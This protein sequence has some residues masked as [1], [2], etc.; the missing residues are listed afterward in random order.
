MGAY[1]WLFACTQNPPEA[2]WNSSVAVA[3]V[4]DGFIKMTFGHATSAS[5]E[6]PVPKEEDR[7]ED[8][9]GQL[10]SVA[11]YLARLELERPLTR[12]EEISSLLLLWWP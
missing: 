2:F 9:G 1:L 8:T 12:D 3:S 10:R 11:S 7:Q 6:D 5:E 4:S